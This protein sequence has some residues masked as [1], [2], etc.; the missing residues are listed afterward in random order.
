[1]SDASW[2]RLKTIL[3]RCLELG[4]AEREAYLEETCGDDAELRARV[5]GLLAKEDEGADPDFL[6]SPFDPSGEGPG[7]VLGDFEI[8]RELG[9]GGM[10][11]V[12]L[13]RQRSLG[14]DVALKVLVTNLAT[15]RRVIERFHREARAAARLQHPGIVQVISDGEASGAHWFAMEFVP[16]HDLHRELALQRGPKLPNARSFLPRPGE[17]EHAASVAA[18][19]AAVADALAFAHEHG[20]VHRDIKP[21]NL[22][23]RPD[24][25]AQI[26]DFGIAR[27]E[28]LGS[29]TRTGELA[30]TPHYMSP[31]QARQSEAA[32]DHRT[33]V[34]S[35]GVV[36]Y[37]LLTHRRPFEGS[38][39]LQVFAKIKDGRPRR[40][41]ELNPKVPRD[42]ETICFKAMARHPDA[43]YASAANM[44]EDLRR[45]LRHEAIVARPPSAAERLRA[46]LVRQR[47]RLAVVALVGLGVW[48][49]GEIAA[50]TWRA[51][52]VARLDVVPAGGSAELAAEVFLR[53]IDP[54]LGLPGPETSLGSLPLEDERIEPGYY[55]VDVRYENGPPRTMV[56]ELRAGERER[57]EVRPPA[58]PGIRTGMV[59]IPG[60]TLAL[61]DEDAPTLA[62]NGHDL[63][64][65]GFW[66]DATEVSNGAYRAFLEATGHPAPPYWARV[67]SEHDA[68]P[69]VEVSWEDARAY[70]EWA[71]KRLPSFAEWT[72]AARGAENRL[73]PWPEWRAGEPRGNVFARLAE[74][75]VDMDAYFRYAAPVD[76]HPEARTASGLFHLFGNVREWT[77]SW[78][79]V[80][81]AGSWRPD[82]RARLVAGHSWYAAEKG[83]DL[84]TFAL[85]GI[86]RIY[87]SSMTG[88]RCALS[89][90]VNH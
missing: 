44:A 33:D 12:Y 9:R 50:S 29:L 52:S 1:M 13:A 74:H 85:Q 86:E 64:I 16:G 35:L 82:P 62:L 3:S 84:T 51:K 39:S 48:G 17:P 46:V 38:S 41:R 5:E 8:Q 61:R 76:S 81:D 42:L 63:P 25:R 60:G 83:H 55:R 70:S 37:E 23:L 72:W 54:L 65:E 24:R 53:P 21:Q 77:E 28:S 18:V 19:C 40:V 66:L 67:E 43:R 15:P 59:W 58:S 22:L 87:A 4:A 32:V 78:V 56:R 80:P 20:V 31:E 34:Y 79:P 75:Y 7:L 27:D 49:G 73:Y 26:L 69:V 36:M 89:Q 57:I 11:V 71:G 30:G 47:A 45:F 2:E 14:R 10:G 68:L 90:D 88:F 6:R